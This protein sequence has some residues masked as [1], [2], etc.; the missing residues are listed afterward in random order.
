MLTEKTK[1]CSTSQTFSSYVQHLSCFY[2]QQAAI[3][4]DDGSYRI[5]LQN[6]VLFFEILSIRDN[7][8][9]YIMTNF[10][11]V[12]VVVLPDGTVKVVLDDSTAY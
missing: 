11:Q 1:L 8:Q 5:K 9:S 3:S 12:T 10:G 7:V 4:M 6:L 2:L